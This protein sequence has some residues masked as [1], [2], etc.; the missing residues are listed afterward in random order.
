MG[1]FGWLHKPEGDKPLKGENKE[2]ARRNSQ[3]T[4]LLNHMDTIRMRS[5]VHTETDFR[6]VI[7][8]RARELGDNVLEVYLNSNGYAVTLSTRE[9]VKSF[10]E[11][12]NDLLRQ[13]EG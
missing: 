7:A 2:E 12:Y 4:N 3:I 13:F 6:Q 11:N 9:D 8:E 1:L 10:V 5:G